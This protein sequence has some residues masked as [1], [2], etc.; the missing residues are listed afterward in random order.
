MKPF[1]CHIPGCKRASDGFTRHDNLLAHIKSVHH[2]NSQ[3]KKVDKEP[4]R[5]QNPKQVIR[6]TKRKRGNSHTEDSE[7]EEEESLLQRYLRLQQ[8]ME[9]LRTQFE[10]ERQEMRLMFYPEK[11]EL[12][13]RHEDELKAERQ[14]NEEIADRLWSILK[15]KE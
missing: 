4:S 7:E 9:A 14:R 2:L 8:E 10:Q 15:P 1:Y 11:E 3:S 6:R 5:E 12:Q 13:R